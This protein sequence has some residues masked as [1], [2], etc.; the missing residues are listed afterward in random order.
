MTDNRM[1]PY[2]AMR[3]ARRTH[4]D[5]PFSVRTL[6]NYIR[7]YN[8]PITCGEL[9]MKGKRKK[10]G[11]RTFARLAHNNVRGESIEKRPPEVNERREVGHWEPD[12]VV[13]AKGSKKVLLVLTERRTRYEYIIL[14]KD[15]SQKSVTSAINRLERGY[16]ARAFRET[17]RS[18]T[19]DNGSEFLD[20]EALEQSCI[21]RGKR[22]KLCYAHPFSSFERGSN[23]NANRMIRRILPK[24]SSFDALTQ[25]D[26]S[27]LETWMNIYPRKLLEGRSARQTAIK[28]KLQFIRISA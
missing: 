18:I 14:L 24:K 12:S 8:F 25:R 28:E 7:Q 11:K 15:K 9:P 4:P 3:I 16:G 23:G 2:A 26:I 21:N 20:Y 1:S 6:Y 19:C 10:C 27:C 17:F 22:T 5:I 13:G